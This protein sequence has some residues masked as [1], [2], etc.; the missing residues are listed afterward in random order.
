MQQNKLWKNGL[1]I[2]LI[3]QVIIALALIIFALVDFTGLLAQFAV[4]YQ[5]DMAI[6]QFIMIYNLFL[7]LSLSL[8]SVFW[9]R[10][11]NL[12]G[13]QAGTT[14]GLLLLLVSLSVFLKFNKL[15]ILLFD[16]IR[17][18]LMVVCGVL[19]FREYKTIDTK[20]SQ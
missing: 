18:L 12:A 7:S 2:L 10:K 14:I 16:G 15:D 4:K 3:F 9:I 17:G 5:P 6:L 8:W 20:I 13:I 19:A 11:N 1:A